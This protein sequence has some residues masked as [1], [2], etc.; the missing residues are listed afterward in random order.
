MKFNAIT[1]TESKDFEKVILDILPYIEMETD[2]QFDH[3]TLDAIFAW[4]T[5]D[6]NGLKSSTVCLPTELYRVYSKNYNVRFIMQ[7]CVCEC[8]GK[9]VLI[10]LTPS[11]TDNVD[12]LEIVTTLMQELLPDIGVYSDVPYYNY[13]FEASERGMES[14][15]LYEDEFVS[16]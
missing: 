5:T 15:I 7:Y 6:T 14:G 8:C 13:V 10:E 12:D 9:I 16:A 3:S 2:I 4:V 1:V 11:N